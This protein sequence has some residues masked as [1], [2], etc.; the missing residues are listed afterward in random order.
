VRNQDVI[1]NGVDAEHFQP[2]DE[3]QHPNSCVFWGRLDF[4]PNIQA[5]QWFCSQVW[6][7]LRQAVP[8]ARFTI[9]GFQPTA[10]VLAL[11]RPY[12]GVEVVPDQPDIR[13]NVR[14]HQVV[15]LPFV[16]GG[17]I[18]NKLLEAASLGKAIICTPRTCG[19]LQDKG[20]APM[21]RAASIPEWVKAL[22]NLWTDAEH[23]RRLG[24]EARNW[25]VT[26]HTWQ[27]TAQSAVAGLESHT[28]EK[29]RR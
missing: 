23:R 17:G 28:C 26:H 18:K 2:G 13:S 16:S 11:V 9:Y 6:P 1:P 22:T 14:G 12:Q 4:G 10:P 20:G 27:A 3:P 5:L 15:V 19:G 25:V 7:A 8:D 21:L 29:P 24:E